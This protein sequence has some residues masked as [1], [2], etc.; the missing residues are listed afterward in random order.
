[1]PSSVF[2]CCAAEALD[3]ST[4]AAAFSSTYM[5]HVYTC[6][7][8]SQRNSISKPDEQRPVLINVTGQEATSNRQVE[9]TQV[10]PRA[11]MVTGEGFRSRQASS[12][13]LLCSA[14]PTWMFIAMTF[15]C[16]VAVPR[17][18]MGGVSQ[19]TC[20]CVH[21]RRV[22]ELRSVLHRES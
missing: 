10:L 1:M 14:L 9:N 7:R 3:R 6:R 11:L 5:A 21:G 22:R 4:S 17:H 16:R 2:D 12:E 18:L 8:P 20:T 19:N 15:F 13:C